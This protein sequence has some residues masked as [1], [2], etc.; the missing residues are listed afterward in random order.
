MMRVFKSDVNRKQVNNPSENRCEQ[1]KN[2]MG[3][4]Y[5]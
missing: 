1:D 4:P 2:R 5:L 3:L